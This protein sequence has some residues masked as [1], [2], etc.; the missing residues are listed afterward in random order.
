MKANIDKYHKAAEQAGVKIGELFFSCEW[1][2]SFW[3]IRAAP[4]AE[5]VRHQACNLHGIVRVQGFPPVRSITCCMCMCV[6][7][8]NTCVTV[9][10]YAL[11]CARSA[12]LRLR[13]HPVRHGHAA[14]GGPLQ[15]EAGQEAG[16]GV[17][18]HMFSHLCT[19]ALPHHSRSYP[20]R[21]RSCTL[22]CLPKPGCL[23]CGSRST[24]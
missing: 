15:E 2:G 1:R 5:G 20:P 18:H 14:D 3:F 10:T 12:L 24:S 6:H 19:A 22:L 23:Q 13:Q 4:W 17:T 8:S 21:P 7:I 11:V 9:C 16:Q